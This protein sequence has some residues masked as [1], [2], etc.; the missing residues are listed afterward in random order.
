MAHCK[1]STLLVFLT[2]LVAA[3]A[4]DCP[5]D[6]L[7]CLQSVMSKNQA[8][9]AEETNHLREDV[10]GEGDVRTA[11][12]NEATPHV[13][14]E[15]KEMNE[16]F[17]APASAE[18]IASN[19]TSN[20]TASEEDASTEE[21]A[22]STQK[23]CKKCTVC[24][25]RAI[26]ARTCNATH[27]TVCLCDRGDFFNALSYECKPCSPCPHGWGVWR[28]CTR[29]RNT[30]CRKCPPGTYSGVLSGSMGC[31][32]CSSCRPDQVMLQECSRIQDTVC[33]G[34]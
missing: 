5:Q 26:E 7:A 11:S 14:S 22:T 8:R 28:V 15:L 19:A 16:T 23:P 21:P 2:A 13:R 29:N 30:V 17:C 27:D 9:K 33:I 18:V 31:V 24:P 10:P 12:F 34:E 4:A 20:G 32:L 3:L 25:K 1:T 6:P